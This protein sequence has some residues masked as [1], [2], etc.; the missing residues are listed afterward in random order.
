MMP[1]TQL[2]NWGSTKRLKSNA[3]H[4]QDIFEKS[5]KEKIKPKVDSKPACQQQN[6]ILLRKLEKSSENSK[7]SYRGCRDKTLIVTIVARGVGILEKR[8]ITGTNVPS[9]THKI[10]NF[11]YVNV[12]F[13]S[14]KL[15]MWDSVLYSAAAIPAM[16]KKNNHL[17]LGE[18]AI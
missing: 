8:V 18:S 7:K 14:Y 12:A 13:I 16:I 10:E 4:I 11:N 15:T 17:D 9:C 2:S 6:H 1:S 3:I 5:A